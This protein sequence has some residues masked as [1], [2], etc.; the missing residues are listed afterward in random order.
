MEFLMFHG[1]LNKTMSRIKNDEL[2]QACASLDLKEDVSE[3]RDKKIMAKWTLDM[4]KENTHEPFILI[5]S[6]SI[7]LSMQ[8]L[9]LCLGEFK[10]LLDVLFAL[11]F[12]TPFILV[13]KSK[14]YAGGA[15]LKEAALIDISSSFMFFLLA[16][17][18]RQRIKR[19]IE[20]EFDYEALVKPKA[21]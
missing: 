2:I 17:R 21:K 14:E 8:I 18:E 15:F 11:L 20:N 9:D 19:K 3:L 10:I 5:D 13:R 7:L 6:H 4:L 12:L 16:Q 1:A